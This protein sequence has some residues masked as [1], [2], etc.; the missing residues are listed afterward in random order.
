[1][2]HYCRNP[3]EELR[4]LER[5]F[6]ADPG[7][8]G[9]KEELK[10]RYSRTG[11][12]P[13]STAERLS[14]SKQTRIIRAIE[15]D[16]PC[17]N[18]DC[19][20]RAAWV[21]GFTEVAAYLL[22]HATECETVMKVID[23]PCKC[24]EPDPSSSFYP[25]NEVC[26]ICQLPIKGE[27]IDIFGINIF[28]EP[29]YLPRGWDA[30]LEWF[31]ENAIQC[32]ECE[33]FNFPDEEDELPDI[34]GNCRHVF[35]E[36]QNPYRRNVDENIRSLERK[37]S[38]TNARSDAVALCLT[39]MR[40]GDERAGPDFYTWLHDNYLS[41][42]DNLADWKTRVWLIPSNEADYLYCDQCGEDVAFD[43]AEAYN[44]LPDSW[45]PMEYDHPNI[46]EYNS[47]AMR[48]FL[49]E[50]FSYED[51]LQLLENRPELN[52]DKQLSCK[53]CGNIIKLRTDPIPW[54][55]ALK[56]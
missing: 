27:N 11:Q 30:W 39:R 55:E 49:Q 43:Y 23:M 29:Y 13:E 1:M 3:D 48:E 50:H 9:L 15:T 46:A 7:N 20:I 6:I 53:K 4:E 21:H 18:S 24:E 5:E 45:F 19:D 34:C 35:G 22:M 12:Y 14:D 28:N 54:R 51:I 44:M 2:A 33:S 52:P 25:G 56:D 38:Q 37:L 10:R 31:H 26:N 47:D 16:H 40:T 8:E 32:P 17:E 36:R 41:H 42:A